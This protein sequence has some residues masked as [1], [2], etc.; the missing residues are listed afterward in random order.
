MCSV[1]LLNRTLTQQQWIA[2]VFLTSGVG[3]VQLYSVDNGHASSSDPTNKF[4]DNDSDSFAPNQALGLFA[5]VCACL[6][7]GFAGCYF[8]KVLKAP[9]AVAATYKPSVWVRNVQLSMFGLTAG[10]PIVLWEMRTS[11]A[12]AGQF[13]A[14][15]AAWTFF[16]GFSGVVW[17]VVALQVTGGLLGGE[18]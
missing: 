11:W 17:L 8:E 18:D 10:L 1:L 2:L 6:I 3:I 9:G 7:S 16:D 14:A 15:T 5:V 12:E 4:N 13:T